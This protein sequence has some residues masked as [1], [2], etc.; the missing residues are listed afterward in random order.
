ML[1]AEMLVVAVA[2]A[3]CNSLWA[4]MCFGVRCSVQEC[5]FH[6][7]LGVVHHGVRTTL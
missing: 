1:P 5:L 6:A 4:R 2:A 3:P 7:L